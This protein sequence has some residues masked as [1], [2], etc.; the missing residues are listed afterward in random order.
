MQL[1][2]KISISLDSGI[3]G[4]IDRYALDHAA[5]G[6]SAV[7]VKALQLLRLTEEES[8][9]ADAYAASALQDK[10]MASEFD[11]TL[12]DGLHKSDNSDNSTQAAHAA[13]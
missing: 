11:R 5:K 8:N 13:W 3:L 1:S 9:L 4:F 7:V 12:A 10:Q 6:R 2:Q